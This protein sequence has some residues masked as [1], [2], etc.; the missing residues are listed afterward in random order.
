MEN[1]CIDIQFS[2]IFRPE[3]HDIHNFDSIV[4]KIVG[5][6]EMLDIDTQ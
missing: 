4:S 2:L 5:G 6:R 1:I 3:L